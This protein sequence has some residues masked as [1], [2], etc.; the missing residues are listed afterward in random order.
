M[1]AGH[2]VIRHVKTADLPALK[3]LSKSIG[4]YEEGYFEACFERVEKE[5]R[6]FY[7]AVMDGR[8]CGYVMLV[9]Q[10]RYTP[11]R[12]LNVP[13]IQDL[14]VAP[15]FRRRG[16]G[17]ALISFCENRARSKNCDLIGIAVG[18]HKSYGQAQRLYI[19]HGYIPDGAGVFYDNVPVEFG[20]MRPMD[21]DMTLKMLKTL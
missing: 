4:D 10:P 1:S 9:W 21:D 14:N 8:V 19:R 11:F 5:E 2:P 18:L 3:R 12:R 17:A 16:I 15:S 6:D 7:V 20:A 13:E